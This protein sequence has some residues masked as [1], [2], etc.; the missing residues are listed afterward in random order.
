MANVAFT[1]SPAPGVTNDLIAVIYKTT[2]PAAE[3]ARI[4][5]EAPHP[6]PYNFLFPDVEPGT[7]IVKIHE[8][9]DGS[10]L[11]N[12]RH[13]FWVDASLQK[14][15]SYTVK[16]FQVGLGRGT[17][18][19]DPADQDDEYINPDL[20]GLTYTV[21][22]PG[23]GPLDWAANITP[24]AGGGF[25]FTDNQKFSQDE[26]YTILIGNLVTQPITSSGGSGFPSDIAAVTAD[27]TFSSEHY[28]K[29]LLIDTVSP[30]LTITIPSFA[31]IP[32]GTMF[33]I[34]TERH[35]GLLR[36]VLLQLPSTKY[37]IIN[38]VARN[39]IPIGK[40][41]EATF[42]KKGDYL[43]II[44]WPGDRHRVGEKVFADGITPPNGVYL[45]GFWALKSDYPRLFPWHVNVLPLSEL[46]LGTDDVIPEGENVRKWIIG[47]NKFWFPD[48]REM[49]YRVS[50]GSRVSNSYQADAIG[51]GQVKTQV[52]TGQGLGKNGLPSGT[53]GVGILGTLGDGGFITT[54]SAT[55]L[56]NNSAH[57]DPWDII[58]PAGE[59]RVKNVATNVYVII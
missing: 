17:P 15:Q 4:L 10:T 51:P 19:Y 55:G 8:T 32:D 26:I 39:I 37:C 56:N 14:L 9:P 29:L 2:A 3:I 35:N 25:D 50:G 49:H 22:K 45:S 12:L 52:F 59:T 21:F 13:D 30:L 58:S 28:K 46:G 24:H 33:G 53:P 11:G 47:I 5:K 48:H 36:Y 38:G 18:Y 57:T 40:C 41:E 6:D 42:M 31:T 44:N 27:L 20:N 54:D 7:Y 34:N 23:Y 16:T 43:H 1:I